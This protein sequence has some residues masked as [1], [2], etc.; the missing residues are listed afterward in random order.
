MGYPRRVV[1]GIRAPGASPGTVSIPGT[2]T[3]VVFGLISAKSAD[4]PDMYPQNAQ[5]LRICAWKRSRNSGASPAR[6]ARGMLGMKNRTAT[7]I[8]AKTGGRPSISFQKLAASPFRRL[9]V[10]CARTD[11]WEPGAGDRPGPPGPFRRPVQPS[12]ADPVARFP[13]ASRAE[14]ES[15]KPGRHRNS[16]ENRWPPFNIVSTNSLRPCFKLPGC[17]R[18]FYLCALVIL[19]A[20]TTRSRYK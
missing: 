11:L 14:V 5:I 3:L 8:H 20:N 13:F 19:L 12:A 1:E 10:N 18:V 16:H 2:C 17:H 9:G 15:E 4:N 6:F 7:G